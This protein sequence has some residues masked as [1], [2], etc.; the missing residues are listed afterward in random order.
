MTSPEAAIAELQDLLA[1]ALAKAEKWDVYVAKNRARTRAR[2]ATPEGRVR[3]NAKRR[4][5]RD[6]RWAADPEYRARHYARNQAYEARQADPIKAAKAAYHAAYHAVWL[7][8]G[9]GP[10]AIAAGR[11]AREAVLLTAVAGRE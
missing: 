4:V 6:R 8:S 5:K 10:E 9:P 11:A 7:V 2:D 1:E 3:L